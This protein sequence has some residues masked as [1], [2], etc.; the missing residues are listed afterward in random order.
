MKKA[1]CLVFLAWMSSTL[2]VVGQTEKD[3]TTESTESARVEE[4]AID[5]AAREAAAKQFRTMLATGFGLALGLGGGIFLLRLRRQN[6]PAT[7]PV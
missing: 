4:R 6:A 3:P 7:P 1:V 5:L 2:V